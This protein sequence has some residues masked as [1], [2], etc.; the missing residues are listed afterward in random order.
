MV[1]QIAVLVQM[2][3]CS[4]LRLK[5]AK[6]APTTPSLAH[7]AAP[8]PANIGRVASAGASAGAGDS[9]AISEGPP[10]VQRSASLPEPGRE[11]QAVV[12]A[13]TTNTRALVRDVLGW[14]YAAVGAANEQPLVVL[15]V[16][17]MS[18]VTDLACS[19]PGGVLGKPEVTTLVTCVKNLLQGGRGLE[20]QGL[21]DATALD[22]L[23]HHTC[24]CLLSVLRCHA[25]MLLADIADTTMP[26]LICQQ[27]RLICRAP[28][29]LLCP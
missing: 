14:L 23:L 19:V 15:V 2:V 3:A 22:Q 17:A 9:E 4:V 24:R 11:T 21:M 20:A 16:Q 1:L 27:V 8:P 13:C 26:D 25:T 29:P 10:S 7:P 28:C 6:A 18:V 5:Q 12:D